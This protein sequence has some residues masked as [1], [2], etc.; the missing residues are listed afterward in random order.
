MRTN[1]DDIWVNPYTSIRLFARTYLSIKDDV[2]K[3]RDFKVTREGWITS[4]FLIALMKHSKRDWWL[5]PNPEDT[6]PDFF[7]SSFLRNE[8]DQYTMRSEMKVDVFEWRKESTFETF[9]EAL[10]KTKLEKVFDPKLTLVCYV[11]KNI[12]I[13]PVVEL[14]EKIKSLKN[15]RIKDIWYLGDITSDSS[16]WR[17][18]QMYPNPMAIDINYDEILQT[19]E[20]LSFVHSYR[21]KSDKFEYETTGKQV[22][23]K[24][25]YFFELLDKPTTKI[26]N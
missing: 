10:V 13:P 7:C 16:I 12:V 1:R 19:K 2:F 25:D 3:K 24:P 15:L 4:M 8:T 23:L 9:F 11:R 17:V 22:T 6:S 14:N 20:P 5:R 18:A 21:A 26:N